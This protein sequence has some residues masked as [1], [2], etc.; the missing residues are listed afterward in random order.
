MILSDAHCFTLLV[1]HCINGWICPK[2]IYVIHSPISSTSKYFI[3][4]FDCYYTLVRVIDNSFSITRSL[5]KSVVRTS[6]IPV[7]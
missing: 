5:R 4:F 7:V 6:V 1:I 2:Y 3:S